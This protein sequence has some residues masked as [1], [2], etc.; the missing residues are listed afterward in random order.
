MRRVLPGGDR[1][2]A[3]VTHRFVHAILKQQHTRLQR[4]FLV[5][6]H[7]R[8]IRLLQQPVQA[9]EMKTTRAQL[10]DGRLRGRQRLAGF[11]ARRSVI[12]FMQQDDRTIARPAGDPG[13]DAFGI[14]IKTFQAPH[15]PGNVTKLQSPQ[16]I[17]QPRAG[18]PGRHPRETRR[19]TQNIGKGSVGGRKFGEQ[20]LGGRHC[21]AI[22]V[23]VG[24][25]ADQ[26]TVGGRSRDQ[27]RVMTRRLAHKKTRR[28]SARVAATPA[29]TGW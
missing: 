24:V 12:K 27:I 22:T 29:I 16:Y 19:V 9:H 15:V 13:R 26:V 21:P 23:P 8:G 14:A 28:I 10:I 17:V 1:G 5:A 6:R 7:N 3:T 4:R 2:G 11:E 25:I 18:Y 20:S